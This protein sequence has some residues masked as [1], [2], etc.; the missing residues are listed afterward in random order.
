[1]ADDQ[2]TWASAFDSPCL[3][4][5]G[6]WRL[7][8]CVECE[9]DG[10]CATHECYRDASSAVLHMDWFRDFAS[11]GEAECGSVGGPSNLVPSQ[12]A[13]RPCQLPAE[14]EGRTHRA[15]MGWSWPAA[16]RAVA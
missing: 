12:Y 5:L 3:L 8:E 15:R 14:H 1:M 13:P 16:G 4:R 7:D 9:L 10:G 6:P 2:L 11:P